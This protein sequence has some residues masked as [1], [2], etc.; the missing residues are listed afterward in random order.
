MSL[1]SARKLGLNAS[2][3]NIILP[4]I[5]IVL[6]VVFFFA[7]FASAISGIFTGTPAPSMLGVFGGFIIAFVAIVAIALAGYI[8]FMVAMY[9]FSNYYSEPAIFKNVLYGLILSIVSAVVVFTLE[10][11]SLLS[12][13]ASIFST[14]MPTTTPPFGLFTFTYLGA[15]AVSIAF[16]I[17][18]GW[19][20]MRAFNKLKEKSRVDNFGT[21][22][23]L[24]LI[25]AIIPLVAW[26]A[27]IFAAMGFSN[28]KPTQATAQTAYTTQPT[29]TAMQ[30]KRCSQCGA[31]NSVEALFCKNCGK[32]F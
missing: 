5:A 2:R 21:A 22:G 10:I 16:G 14:S 7:V 31:E 28:L 27:W 26:I 30:T 19:L 8:M 20:Y 1:E 23:L 12:S 25:G 3:I 15:I 4:I 29:Y 9:R 32:Q 11:A 17:V 18:N 6:V 24:F 13:I